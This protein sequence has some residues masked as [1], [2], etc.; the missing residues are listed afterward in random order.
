[1]SLIDLNRVTPVTPI[2]EFSKGTVTKVSTSSGEKPG[3]SVKMVTVGLVKS[4]KTSTGSSL[5]VLIPRIKTTKAKANI[6]GL[7]ESENWM[8]LL[9]NFSL[10]FFLTSLHEHLNGNERNQSHHA[11]INH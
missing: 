6:R 11:C 5:A 3:D 8:S 4:G 10:T 1:M 7:W 2:R 9:S